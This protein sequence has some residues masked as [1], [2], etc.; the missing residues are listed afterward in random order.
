M[1]NLKFFEI[2][3]PTGM[4]L[5]Q[6]LRCIR[7]PQFEGL[8][9]VHVTIRCPCIEAVAT[10]G[11]GHTF[12]FSQFTWDGLRYY[13]LRHFGANITTLRLDSGISLEEYNEVPVSLDF[14][15]SLNAVQVIEFDGAIAN[16][17]H[18]ILSISGIFPV[19]KV[20]RV[21]VGWDDCERTLQV[22]VA[23][24]RLRMEEGKPLAT[25]EPLAAEGEDGLDQGLRDEWRRYYDAGG[26]QIFL[27]E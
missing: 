16:R 12:K 7:I 19:L 3:C 10:D 6:M 13:P 11:S 5:E 25:I 8:D 17:A 1:T 26:I 23:V 27:S 9:T 2:D 20:I 4:H 22:L 24:S 21:T 14:F 15:L 18:R